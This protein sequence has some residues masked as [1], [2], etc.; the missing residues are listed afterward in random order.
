MVFTSK[1]TCR[2]QQVEQACDELPPA[3]A[4]LCRPFKRV[5][6]RKQLKLLVAVKPEHMDTGFHHALRRALN[7]ECETFNSSFSHL[8]YSPNS[9]STVRKYNKLVSISKLVT[10][11]ASLRFLAP[12]VV[13]ASRFL[14]YSPC[15][16]IEKLDL[17]TLPVFSELV[18]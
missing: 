3:A 16:K 17:M 8:F 9:P 12:G 15:A 2:A 1:V 6:T 4:P 13:P 14:G 11:Q 5:K 18:G 10:N 7:F